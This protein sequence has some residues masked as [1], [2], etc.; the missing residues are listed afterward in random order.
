[1]RL[2]CKY[3][4]AKTACYPCASAPLAL[5]NTMLGY[6]HNDLCSAHPTPIPVCQPRRTCNH[7]NLADLLR[8]HVVVIHALPADQ[9]VRCVLHMDPRKAANVTVSLSH[10]VR[11][12]VV[13]GNWGLLCRTATLL[14]LPVPRADSTVALGARSSG[15]RLD[16]LR[17]TVILG[18]RG[19]SWPAIR[20]D[21]SV[22]PAH[23][24]PV[25][26]LAPAESVSEANRSS[27]VAKNLRCQATGFRHAVLEDD[28]ANTGV[29]ERHRAHDAWLVGEENLQSQAEVTIRL[30]VVPLKVLCFEVVEGLV[31]EESVVRGLVEAESSCSE[32]FFALIGSAGGRL[33]C[34]T[35]ALPAD[36]ADGAH[37]SMAHGVSLAWMV[38]IVLASD[39]GRVWHRLEAGVSGSSDDLCLVLNSL[40][41][42]ATGGTLRES[43]IVGLF[44]G[45]FGQVKSV[46]NAKVADERMLKV[47]LGLGDGPGVGAE[48]VGLAVEG[49]PVLLAP[50]LR[51]LGLGRGLTRDGSLL[52]L[53]REGPR[54]G[55]GSEGLV[56]DHQV[57]QVGKRDQVNGTDQQVQSEALLVQGTLLDRVGGLPAVSLGILEHG[58]RSCVVP[59]TL[60]TVHLFDK[61]TLANDVVGHKARAGKAA[62]V[63]EVDGILAGDVVFDHSATT[64]SLV[65]GRVSSEQQCW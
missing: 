43:L 7:V 45:L 5:S 37:D 40:H 39:V 13:V 32:G 19:V 22:L 20:I 46:G 16:L 36:H 3:T 56:L 24:L 26:F 8:Y 42:H 51:L 41:N 11:R 29:D 61:V 58:L 30:E 55:V 50:L 28:T 23:E 6:V 12:S 9:S 47:T 25:E 44:T 59:S 64:I 21:G 33:G 18:V 60:D 17:L 57:V 65:S 34:D 15:T 38:T 10:T 31:E 48:G 63:L 53:E 2:V 4:Q 1:M 27:V 62:E 54:V 14:L 35:Q 49:G 52:D